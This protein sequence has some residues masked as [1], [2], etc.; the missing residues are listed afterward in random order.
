MK[1]KLDATNV[2]LGSKRYGAAGSVYAPNNHRTGS[3]KG[4]FKLAYMNPMLWADPAYQFWECATYTEKAKE[5]YR[6]WVKRIV[7]QHAQS[8]DI[9]Q[10]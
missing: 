2:R 3:S 9:S 5:Y 4:R 8:H 6:A 1:R 10:G 7:T